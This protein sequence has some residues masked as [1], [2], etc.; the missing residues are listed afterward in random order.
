MTAVLPHY[1]RGP[2]NYQASALI[3]GG[4]FV[5]PTTSTAGTTDL[6]VAP[7]VGGSSSAGDQFVLGVAGN[8]AN[9]IATQ[10]GT[11]NT[12]G[13]PL[14]DISVLTD[15]VSVYGGGWDIWVWY[16]AAAKPGELLV[17]GSASGVA[18]NGCV[19]GIGSSP[20]YG[21]GTGGLTITPAYNNI[22]GRCTHPGGVSAAMCTQQIGGLS[23]STASYF[24]GRARVGI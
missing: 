19:A 20:Y 1:T 7:S 16:G 18:C 10:T 5:T 11:A 23:T 13:Q 8:D 6:T 2:A 21:A 4:Q 9:T 22:V 24:L 17:V 14:I 3:I 12:Y 15:Y